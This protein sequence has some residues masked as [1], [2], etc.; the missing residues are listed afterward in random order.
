MSQRPRPS[1]REAW[2]DL[3]A[4]VKAP[5]PAGGEVPAPAEPAPAKRKWT[6]APSAQFKG[7]DGVVRLYRD[8][9]DHVQGLKTT[10]VPLETITD[11]TVEDGA[12]L[13]SRITATRLVLVGVF[14][15]AWRKRKGGEKFLLLESSDASI[16]VTVDR[17][18][19]VKAQRFA[20]AVRT[21]ARGAGR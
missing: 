15:L 21:A 16:L 8:G 13:E 11:A 6:E 17:R 10:T 18:D 7:R 3:V 20:A 5:A 4:A 14:A 2:T 1:V 9:V 19:V 12:D